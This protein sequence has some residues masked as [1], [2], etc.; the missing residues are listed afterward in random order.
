MPRP[1]HLDRH[2][3][4]SQQR[5]IPPTL[6]AEKP[7]HAHSP[8]DA[9]PALVEP[10][11]SFL[12]KR[13]Q[14]TIDPEAV[15]GSRWATSANYWSI[16]LLVIFILCLVIVLAGFYPKAS[17]GAFGRRRLLPCADINT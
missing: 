13:L 4:I 6:L 2:T 16:S 17:R 7:K 8:Q 1:N 3:R 12:S 5:P 15:Y 14:K 9:S 10:A 11:S